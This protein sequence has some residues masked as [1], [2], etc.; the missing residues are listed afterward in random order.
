MDKGGVWNKQK[1][2]ALNCGHL[3]PRLCNLWPVHHGALLVVPNSICTMVYI[4]YRRSTLAFSS[5]PLRG[6]DIGELSSCLKDVNGVDLSGQHV[7][8]E[9]EL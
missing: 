4:L 9:D 1:S 7:H 8:D 2:G 6:D 5:T 3:P